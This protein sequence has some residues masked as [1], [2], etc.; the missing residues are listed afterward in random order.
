MVSPGSRCRPWPVQTPS[1]MNGERAVDRGVVGEEI[2]DRGPFCEMSATPENS[3]YAQFRL[4]RTPRTL[5]QKCQC[6]RAWT[7]FLSDVGPLGLDL[8]QHC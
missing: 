4:A 1:R 3:A 6:A 5:L 8:A 2:E 7:C